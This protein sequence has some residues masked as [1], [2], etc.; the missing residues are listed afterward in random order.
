MAISC[1]NSLETVKSFVSK[2]IK[3]DKEF[4]QNNTINKHENLFRPLNSFLKNNQELSAETVDLMV[5]FV[6]EIVVKYY[7]KHYAV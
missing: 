3:K 7:D 6:E 1:Q 4:T 2:I 5:L